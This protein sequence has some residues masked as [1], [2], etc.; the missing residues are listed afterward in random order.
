MPAAILQAMAATA[1]ERIR[2]YGVRFHCTVFLTVFA[3]LLLTVPPVG[4]LCGAQARS[5]HCHCCKAPANAPMAAKNCCG[6]RSERVPALPMTAQTAAQMV[7]A[8]VDVS[9]TRAFEPLD[10]YRSPRTLQTM[11]P[12]PLTPL[13]SPILRI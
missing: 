11:R 9:T 3:L 7:L 1:S 5:G 10:V 2:T 8:A 12:K 13:L 6:A 4:S